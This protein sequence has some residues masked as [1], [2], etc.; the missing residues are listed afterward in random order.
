ME[1]TPKPLALAGKLMGYAATG[2]VRDDLRAAARAL[3][4]AKP[5]DLWRGEHRNGVSRALADAVCG[6]DIEGGRDFAA[7]AQNEY[8]GFVLEVVSTLLERA[9]GPGA[10]DGVVLAGGCGLNV[11][12]NQ[13]VFD[14]LDAAVY[15][16]P[17]PNDAGLA[18][19]AAWKVTPPP[20]RPARPQHLGFGLWDGPDLADAAA[21]RARGT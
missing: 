18:A 17:A 14:E 8:E 10:V 2:S 12:A 19:G 21:A 11:R 13:R 9:G 7:T 4:L 1:R 15:V 20:R 16:A 6:E 3:L 5:A